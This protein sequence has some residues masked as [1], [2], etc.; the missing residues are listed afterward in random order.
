MA[1]VRCVALLPAERCGTGRSLRPCPARF[2]APSVHAGRMPPRLPP[3]PENCRQFC[4]ACRR[5]LKSTYRT[6]RSPACANVCLC[7]LATLP[8]YGCIAPGHAW[9]PPLCHTILTR[10][11][12]ACCLCVA[13]P[14]CPHFIQRTRPTLLRPS[15]LP[16][17][18][19]TPTHPFTA[20]A[21]TSFQCHVP[22][23]SDVCTAHPNHAI[24]SLP[25]A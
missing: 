5:P 19:S 11:S 3:S 14:A 20:K 21:C 8:Y 12:L 7:V 22:L 25:R 4:L 9:P 18:P 13:C 16:A 24:M 15:P 1:F 23:H 6:R 2:A 10:R 17:T